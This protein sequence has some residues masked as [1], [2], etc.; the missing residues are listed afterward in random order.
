MTLYAVSC[1]SHHSDVKEGIREAPV[2]ARGGGTLR[3][4]REAS[5]AHISGWDSV[6]PG[7]ELSQPHALTLN[8]LSCNSTWKVKFWLE[9]A[10]S[11]YGPQN[12]ELGWPFQVLPPHPTPSGPTLPLGT[13]ARPLFPEKE[14]SKWFW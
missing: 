5:S 4:G 8:V 9:L 11:P 13:G 3:S 6:Q 14:P 2:S 12:P 10:Q 7:L 1:A